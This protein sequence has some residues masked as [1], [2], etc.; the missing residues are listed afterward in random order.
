MDHYWM[1]TV[2]NIS[3][4]DPIFL[5]LFICYASYA[6]NRKSVV[7]SMPTIK[8]EGLD[9]SDAGKSLLINFFLWVM[10]MFM[11]PEAFQW[12]L[13]Y[14]FKNLSILLFHQLW[15]QFNAMKPIQTICIFFF[16][17][18]NSVALWINH[19]KD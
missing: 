10:F 16:F 2:L 5:M 15:I 12:T 8:A 11:V 7:F 18:K 4:M 19:L 9:A 17:N 6:L 1:F 14:I 3:E 13:I